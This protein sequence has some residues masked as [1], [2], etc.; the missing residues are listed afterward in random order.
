MHYL[1]G[2]RSYLKWSCGEEKYFNH[3][4]NKR[5]EE[6]INRKEIVIT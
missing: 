3:K 6:R 4:N 2:M 5:K 1:F